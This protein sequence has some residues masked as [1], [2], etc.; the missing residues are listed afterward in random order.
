[1]FSS[2]MYG[3]ALFTLSSVVLMWI[4]ERNTVEGWEDER[5][6]HLG[7]RERVDGDDFRS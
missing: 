5:G 2:I 4:I 6:F 7:R 1:M 3:G